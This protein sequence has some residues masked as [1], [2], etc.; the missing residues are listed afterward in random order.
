MARIVAGAVIRGNGN[1]RGTTR[2]VAVQV[3]GSGNFAR[4]MKS[5]INPGSLITL[6]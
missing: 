5:G 4:V 2:S 6:N 1:H 3:T